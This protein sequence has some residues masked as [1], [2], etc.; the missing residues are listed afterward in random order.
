MLADFGAAI[1]AG[2]AGA[3]AAKPARAASAAAG[4]EEM[5]ETADIVVI[6]LG[7]AGAAA[8]I[9]AARLGASVAVLEKQPEKAHV[10]A[11]RLSSGVF[12]C[13]ERRIDAA[14]LE[15]YIASNYASGGADLL[16]NG[17]LDPVLA[18]YA[19]VWATLAP[20][21]LDWL[22]SLDP[23]F[24]AVSSG[25]LTA[26][27]FI[28]PSDEYWPAIR[29]HISTYTRRA[30]ENRSTFDAPKAEKSRGEA[31]YTCLL[32]GVRKE[33]GVRLH[34]ST[35]AIGLIREDG[36]V[37]G[38]RAADAE[39]RMH[40]FCA[41]R[42]VILAAGGF[43]F[44]REMREGRLPDG[45]SDLWAAAGSPAST[46]DGIRMALEVGGA[47]ISPGNHLARFAVL[48]PEKVSDTRLGFLLTRLGCPHSILTDHYGRR[49][50]P[51][52]DFRESEFHYG[53][54]Q[55]VQ[56][57]DRATLS[58][59][60]LPVWMIFD[61]SVLRSGCLVKLC[62]GVAAT[63]LISW[64][65]DNLEA[66]ER[67][68]ILSAP[69]IDGLARKIAAHENNMGRMRPEILVETVER[70]NQFAAAG[71][72]Y[73]L[74]AAPQGMAELREA[75]FYALPVSTDLPFMSSGLR[76]GPE[77][78]VLDWSGRPIAGLFAAGEMA[79]ASRLVQDRGGSMSDCL[80]F[81]RSVGAHVAMLEP[82]ER[83]RSELGGE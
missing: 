82:H 49:F 31:L 15:R 28:S 57:F 35:R 54:I 55:S 19:R 26:P 24:G 9:D 41:R 30:L 66:V 27:Q 67:G 76:T 81:G 13:P 39:G 64:S 32:N 77:K 37:T 70:F 7:A 48:L 65:P 34:F 60:R 18:A 56:Y 45:L 47:I 6:G 43:G 40:C 16:R 3:I 36:R 83:K 12:Q 10:P 1:T 50:R 78:E 14:V 46:G 11:T 2:S 59:P 44:N 51:E 23:D 5:T 63:G 62:E 79:P 25:S 22:R 29:S 42:G 68:W 53:F 17:R 72:D 21:T 8:A 71:R 74:D 73:D 75:P 20:D 69:T 58:L 38:V 80:V 52:S 4:G 61:A 33:R